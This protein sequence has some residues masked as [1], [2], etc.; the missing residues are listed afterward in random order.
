VP[1]DPSL[2]E[3]ET[4]ESAAPRERVRVAVVA[5]LTVHAGLLAFSA[6]HNAPTIDEPFHLAA[7]IRR[8]QEAA[9]DVDRGNPPL[10]GSIA[11][12]PVLLADP[13]VEW[14]AVPD[15]FAVGHD[16]LAAN[17][18][19]SLWLITL[20][21]WACIPFSLLGGYI[22]YRWGCDL[23]GASSG[24]LSLVLWCFCPSVLAHGQLVT[25]DM[26]AAAVGALAFYLFWRWLRRPCL[27]RAA[28]AGLVWGLAELSKYVWLILYL[29]WPFMWLLLR[30]SG[31][32][33]TGTFLREMGQ[34]A[35]MV[36]LS[37]YII[38]MG[39]M[40][41]R[42]FQPLE[43]VDEGRKHSN[44]ADTGS[45][46]AGRLAGV[47]TPFPAQY[48][49]GLGEMAGVAK[50]HYW[51]YFCGEWRRGGWWHFYPCALLIKLPLGTLALVALG[52]LCGRRGQSHFRGG[53]A[54]PSGLR[55][56]RRESWH[57]PRER[58][59]MSRLS[60]GD[61][62]DDLFLWTPIL[63]ILAF[64]TWSGIAQ[65]VRYALPILPFAFVWA[66]K[67]TQVPASRGVA[68]RIGDPSDIRQI[69]NLPH[70][71]GGIGDPSYASFVARGVPRMCAILMLLAWSTLSALWVYPHSLS[72]FNE[73]AGGP[74]MGHE[75][76]LDSNT[77]WG[78]DLLYFKTWLEEQRE[79]SPLYVTFNGC[80]AP[81]FFGIDS[82]EVPQQLRGAV[83]AD[84]LS[85]RP[86]WYAVSV[87]FLHSHRYMT[88]DPA[89]AVDLSCF[90]SMRPTA[91]AGYSIFIYHVDGDSEGGTACEPEG[92][93]R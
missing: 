52:F 5:L 14:R 64:V 4:R 72:Y 48:L 87:N 42:P 62:R 81:E 85:T 59:P 1:Q 31:D 82:R 65:H 25:G 8:G 16:F 47:P 7:G 90:R 53:D 2:E 67:A 86:G 36:A 34:G 3:C 43:K 18:L 10:A 73:L 11:A 37:L 49:G 54:P 38:N 80:A 69:G 17:G 13:K 68:G 32:K 35:L 66:G 6:A 83:S 70:A 46:S 27:G 28:L 89:A 93:K 61:W 63:V 41:D 45:R 91:M 22:C 15:S 12:L 24:L 57:S 44:L 50:G 33:G 60:R 77:D 71:A 30:R 29:L 56:S 74:I 19:R 21:R 84:E 92:G 40:F 39:Y 55:R 9:F 58:L 51:S 78:Q 88:I 20:A 26:A 75:Y 79:A 76:L 23:H